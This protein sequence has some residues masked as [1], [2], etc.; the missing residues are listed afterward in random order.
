MIRLPGAET[1]YRC[2][3][4]GANV[5]RPVE[6]EVYRCNGCGTLYTSKDEDFHA[7]PEKFPRTERGGASGEEGR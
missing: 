3:E 2:E 4:C 7:V 6:P 1:S 5:F